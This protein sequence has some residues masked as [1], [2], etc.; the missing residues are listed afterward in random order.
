MTSSLNTNSKTRNYKM[1]K[2]GKQWLFAAATVA[3]IGGLSQLDLQANADTSTPSVKM[4]RTA[5]SSTATSQTDQSTTSQNQTSTS[6]SELNQVQSTSSQVAING[7]DSTSQQS[8]TV[9]STESTVTQIASEASTATS[10]STTINADSISNQTNI[11]F[12]QG[13]TQVD[14]NQASVQDHTV[15]INQAGTYQ[16]SGSA[17]DAQIVVNA[18][19]DAAVTIVL[20]NVDLTNQLGA[21]INAKQFG[22]LT[23]TSLGTNT[24]TTSVP[25]ENEESLDTINPNG[26]IYAN[27][28]LIS[29]GDGTLNISSTMNGISA[30]GTLTVDSGNLNVTKSYEALEGEIV[31]INGGNLNL[32]A[33]D[34]I[35]NAQLDQTKYDAGSTDPQAINING[36]NLI[37]HGG[38]DGLDSN[39]DINIAGGNVISMID[40]TPDNGA[41]DGD[42]TISFTG[43]TVLW[44]G[45]GTEGTPNAQTSSQ[46][47]V[48]IGQVSA[49]DTITVAQNGQTLKQ[50]SAPQAATYLNLSMPG[51][52]AGQTYQVSVNGTTTD[53]VAGQGGGSG[54]T[55][56]GGP[57][58]GL[59]NGRPPM[60]GQGQGGGPNRTGTQQ[61]PMTGTSGTNVEPNQIGNQLSHANSKNNNRAGLTSTSAQMTSL[62]DDNRFSQAGTYDQSESLTNQQAASTPT[63]TTSGQSTLPKT[64]NN[65]AST[66]LGIA[67]I[68][69]ALAAQAAVIL[70]FWKVKQPK[71]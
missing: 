7:L 40:S 15:T 33:S 59:G 11:T 46:S 27:G 51:L 31:T 52:T 30:D 8:L 18:P 41:I 50:L 69:A 44:G 6:Q 53:V 70:A 39:G 23:I 35:I 54:M 61:E 16:V 63:I 57:M 62:N 14:T 64:G 37:L 19:V 29:N 58:A 66:N 68:I 56:E 45:T 21:V 5:N 25:V 2:A 34:D 12:N 26:A 24:I 65:D 36:G 10:N 20:N 48:K 67:G 9:S 55:G 13:Q 38:G 43:G 1:Y 4:T 47:Y 3:V 42:G 28:N 49:G 22:N 71:K 60:G 17:A 32:N